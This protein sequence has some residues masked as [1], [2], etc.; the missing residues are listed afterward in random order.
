[1]FAVSFLWCC[2]IS[3]LFG[4]CPHGLSC[5]DRLVVSGFVSE[6]ASWQLVIAYANVRLFLRRKLQINYLLL[7]VFVQT[8]YGLA[9]AAGGT[10]LYVSDW[11]KGAVFKVDVSSSPPTMTEVVSDVLLPMALQYSAVSAGMSMHLSWSRIS[12]VKNYRNLYNTVR[13]YRIRTCRESQLNIT[14]TPSVRNIVQFCHML[15]TIMPLL[16]FGLPQ[17]PLLHLI[18]CFR[19]FAHRRNCIVFLCRRSVRL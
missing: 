4:S 2:K 19:F 5:D 15:I 3:K 14:V 6:S 11:E 12:N 1:M 10:T 9:A 7:Y 17:T 18:L 8:P 13:T 16:L